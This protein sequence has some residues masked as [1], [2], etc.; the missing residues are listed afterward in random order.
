MIRIKTQPCGI[1][2]STDLFLTPLELSVLMF[3]FVCMEEREFHVADLDERN[4]YLCKTVCK[5]V[6]LTLSPFDSI[7]FFQFAEFSNFEFL[8]E[9]FGRVGFKIELFNYF[10]RYIDVRKSKVC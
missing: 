1:F 3:K 2:S 5:L 7:F 9:R 8:K 6:V 4:R 10:F